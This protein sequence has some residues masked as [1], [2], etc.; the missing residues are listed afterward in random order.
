MKEAVKKIKIEYSIIVKEIME[1]QKDIQLGTKD[2]L[3]KM[4][5]EYNYKKN[6]VMNHIYK[7]NI[8][9]FQSIVKKLNK[10]LEKKQ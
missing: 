2:L 6:I 7:V 9:Y 10:N 5:K 3:L 1:K 8:N 4:I